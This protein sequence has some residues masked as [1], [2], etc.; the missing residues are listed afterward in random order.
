LSVTTRV[1]NDLD[2]VPMVPPFT[3]LRP[4]QHFSPE[5][6]LKPGP[7]YVYLDS[8]DADRLSVGQFWRNLTDFSAKDHRMDGYLANIEFKVAN[9][10]TQVPYLFHQ[11]KVS[12]MVEA[13]NAAG[14]A[15]SQ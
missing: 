6:L 3:R 8:H 4:Y 13:A 12:P 10:A 14:A 15:V 11:K 1:V 5:V 9:G 7:Y 2:V